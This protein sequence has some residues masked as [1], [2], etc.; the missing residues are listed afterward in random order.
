MARKRCYECKHWK[1]LPAY[2]GAS[3]RGCWWLKRGL[4]N[5]ATCDKF[6][7]RGEGGRWEEIKKPPNKGEILACLRKQKRELKRIDE[8]LE[9]LRGLRDELTER[10]KRGSWRG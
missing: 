3:Y 1:K 8:A 5:P 2:R 6:E 7:P 4:V 10:I 9:E